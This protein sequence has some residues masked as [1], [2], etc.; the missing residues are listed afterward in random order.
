MSFFKGNEEQK[1]MSCTSCRDCRS[2]SND[3]DLFESWARKVLYSFSLQ[4]EALETRIPQE[5]LTWY[6]VTECLP[7]RDRARCALKM[8]DGTYRSGSFDRDE[9][10]FLLTPGTGFPLRGVVEWAAILPTHWK[11]K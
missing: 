3:R 7:N 2:Y 4:L 6:N 9:G 11:D 10:V 1:C 5:D 8:A